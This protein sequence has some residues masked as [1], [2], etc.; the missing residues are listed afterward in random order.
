MLRYDRKGRISWWLQGDI[1]SSFQKG[2]NNMH[3]TKMSHSDPGSELQIYDLI[4]SG[5]I[6]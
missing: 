4:S 1:P 2:L 3:S 6:V 5:N